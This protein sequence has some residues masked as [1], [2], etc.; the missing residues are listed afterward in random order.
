MANLDG[1]T[2]MTNEP[3]Q[4]AALEVVAWLDDGLSA[5]N[6]TEG[7]SF[8]VV[9]DKTRQDMPRAA[10]VS[11]TNALVRLSEAEEAL[12]QAALQ[13]VSLFGELQRSIEENEALRAEVAALRVDRDRMDW[14]MQHTVNVRV[15]LRYGSHNLFWAGPEE[16]DGEILPSDLRNR[17]DSAI[18]LAAKEAKP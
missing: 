11:Y 14:L 15:H 5:C 7:A 10:A 4:P 18:A 13:Y 16:G 12:Q 17:I 1:A 9:T 3:K 8:R 6:G 2:S